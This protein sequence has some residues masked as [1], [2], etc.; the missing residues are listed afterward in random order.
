MDDVNKSPTQMAANK[1]EAK[2]FK[3]DDKNEVP[4]EYASSS[5]TSSLG[6]HIESE[7]LRSGKEISADELNNVA[8]PLESIDIVGSVPEKKGYF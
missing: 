3:E 2:S 1:A 7:T 4:P 8:G 6:E 5:I